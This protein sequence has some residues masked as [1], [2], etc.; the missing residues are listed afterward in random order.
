MSKESPLSLLS[1]DDLSRLLEL[2]HKS[3]FCSTEEHLASL[4]GDLKW[5]F[6]YDFAVCALHRAGTVID[7]HHFIN[8]NFPSDWCSLYMAQGFDKVD[9][10]VLESGRSGQGIQYWTD[11]Y[12]KY[13]AKTTRTFISTA[14]DF[15]LKEGYSYGV[16]APNENKRSLFNFAGGSVDHHPRT[17][18]ILEYAIPHLDQAF[19]RIV[20]QSKGPTPRNPSAPKLS[21][22]EKEVLNWAKDGKSIWETSIILSISQNTVQFHLKNIMAKLAVVNKTQAV[23]VAL[24]NGLIHSE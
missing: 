12:K 17:E 6:P 19:N 24:H 2:I 20:G 1:Q 9:P 13:R 23:A 11:T 18:C 8:V 10:I 21:S 22:R 15:G 7:P 14:Q 4:L 3:L 16:R 5:L